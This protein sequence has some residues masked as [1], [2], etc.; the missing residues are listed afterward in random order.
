[1]NLLHKNL[2]PYTQIHFK[3]P[4]AISSTNYSLSFSTLITNANANGCNHFLAS[5]RE[6]RGGNETVNVLLTS[7]FD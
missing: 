2:L 1:M 3:N 6:Y 4:F 5:I 7:I